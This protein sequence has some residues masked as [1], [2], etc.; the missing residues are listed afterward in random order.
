M[1]KA[2]ISALTITNVYIARIRVTITHNVLII[3]AASNV[4]APPA[5]NWVQVYEIVTILTNVS[6]FQI[7]ASMESVEIYWAVFNVFVIRDS[8]CR[9]R[10]IR[11]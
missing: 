9:R 2:L 10:E 5:T 3:R 4:N 8:I 1:T 6:K 11:V 7:C